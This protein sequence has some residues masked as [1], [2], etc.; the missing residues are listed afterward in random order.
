VGRFWTLVGGFL[1]WA[2]K[3]WN[4]N[5]DFR[6]KGRQQEEDLASTIGGLG[7]ITP[8]LSPT[9]MDPNMINLAAKIHYFGGCL[10]FAAVVYFCRVAFLRSVTSK[11][12]LGDGI[13]TFLR[14]MNS[15]QPANPKKA[16]RGRVYVV[17]SFAIVATLLG[18][19]VV[20]IA[21]P[22][23]TINDFHMTFWAE[24]VA[25]AFFGV[26]WVTACQ[27]W[28]WLRDPDEPK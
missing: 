19:L 25:L 7:A 12:N 9:A 21:V 2:S 11:L 20:Q 27:L 26:A 24:L 5:I 15:L 13:L 6:V 17:C 14:Q 28:S 18:L 10:L 22:Q 16:M 3:L 8:V 23:A 1:N 4:G